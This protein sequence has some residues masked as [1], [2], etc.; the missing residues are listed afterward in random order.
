MN[1]KKK[2]ALTGSAASSSSNAAAASAS[3]SSASASSPSSLL[4]RS[5][6]ASASAASSK[7]APY[8]FSPPG[9]NH[10]FV[11]GP[12]NIH[13]N[14]LRAMDRPSQNHRDPWFAPFLK[15]ILEDSKMI[16]GTKKGTPFIYPGTGTGG[17]E[18]A[19]TNTLSPGDKVVT[20]R[21]GQ[22]S[23]LWIGKMK[24]RFFFFS[25]FFCF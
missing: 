16:F 17:W 22:F 3:A 20:F 5:F 10:L 6:S 9:R 7:P 8:S 1:F 2:Q 23:H 18:S 12:V 13:E 21:Y 24:E 19:L 25:E 4:S 15:E 11:P 14:V